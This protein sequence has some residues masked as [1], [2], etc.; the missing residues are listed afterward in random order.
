VQVA[1]HTGQALPPLTGAP[2]KG[3]VNRSRAVTVATPQILARRPPGGGY[4]CRI[5]SPRLGRAERRVLYLSTSDHL[6]AVGQQESFRLLLQLL[7][8]AV[9]PNKAATLSA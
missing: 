5:P 2:S 8:R 3:T 6:P 4:A 7:R 1:Q 9:R